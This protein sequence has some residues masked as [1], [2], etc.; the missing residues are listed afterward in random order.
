MRHAL[1]MAAGLLSAGGIGVMPRLWGDTALPVRPP[2]AVGE[3]AFLGACIKCGLCVQAC[4]VEAIKLGDA[5]LGFG[6]G[7]AF[8]D[9]REQS[10]GYSCD[11]LSCVRA[12]PSGALIQK[13]TRLP[14]HRSRMGIAVL[15]SPESCLASQGRSFEGLVRGTTFD[16]VL[17]NR[18]VSGWEVRLLNKTHFSRPLCNMC[19]L[20]CPI[21]RAIRMEERI[22]PKTGEGIH[23]PVVTKHCLGC[24]VC[25]MVCPTQA[26]SIQVIARM[27]PGEIKGV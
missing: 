26:A 6:M 20:E 22:H 3:E 10:C 18:R 2:G 1:L 21:P 5:N 25:E 9:A 14:K 11:N 16:G 4:P 13:V 12:C 23:L 7:T 8:I 19:I 17:R 27:E 15:V 24:G